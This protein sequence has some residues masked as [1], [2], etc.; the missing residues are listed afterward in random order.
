LKRYVYGTEKIN[1]SVNLRTIR[2]STPQNYN[3]NN[4]YDI[5]H[6]IMTFLVWFIGENGD[7]GIHVMLRISAGAVRNSPMAM[8]HT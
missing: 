8:T 6:C 4:V 5:I 1:V 3:I 7:W 2:A